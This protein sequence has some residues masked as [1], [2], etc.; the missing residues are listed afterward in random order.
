MIALIDVACRRCFVS[1][2]E[3]RK[4]SF[5]SEFIMLGKQSFDATEVIKGRWCSLD[6]LRVPKELCQEI[7]ERNPN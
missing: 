6:P 7:F 3:L 1:I 5:I 2:L 4:T